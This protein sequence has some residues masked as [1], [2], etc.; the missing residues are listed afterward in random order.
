MAVHFFRVRRF[1]QVVRAGT[2]LLPAWRSRLGWCALIGCALMQPAVSAQEQPRKPFVEPSETHAKTRQRAVVETLPAQNGRWDMLPFHMPIN[3]VHVA[4]MRSGKVLIVSGSGNDPDNKNLQ[5]AVWDPAAATIRTF[6]IGWDMFCDG[7]VVLPDGRPLILGGTKQYDPFLGLPRSAAFDPVSEKFADLPSMG[8]GR[9]YPSGVVLGNGS[10]MVYSGQNDTDGTINPVVQLWN[11]TAWAA[12]GGIFPSLP[13]YPRGHLLP[14]GKVFESGSNRDSQLYDPVAHTWSAVAVT[15]FPHERDYGTSVLL[16]LTPANAWKPRVMILGGSSSD[17]TDTTELIDLSAPTPRWSD[18][19][20]MG[21]PRIHL[22]A[23]LLPN[24]KLLVS[25]GSVVDEDGSTAVKEAQLYDPDANSFSSAS[26]ME[27]PRLYHSNTLLL[28]DARVVALGGNP[29]RKVYQPEIEI[30]SPPYLFNTDGSPARRPAITR[31]T[32]A[33]VLY[34]S[35]FSVRSPDATAIKSVVLL[36]A[37]AATHAFDMEQRLVGLSFTAGPGALTVTAPKNG[38]L[39]PPGY[40]L[41]FILNA[42][43]VP[44]AAQFVRLAAPLVRGKR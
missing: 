17:T 7:M 12:G 28:P 21:K 9:W 15:N 10:V 39:A 36:R 2:A 16:P 11:G 4:L 8:A 18:G 32:P 22:N 38:N 27:V 6:Q 14:T 1:G 19:P 44:S 31:V 34:G 3:P 20:K 26:S 23:T 40:Y 42:Q 24:G 25:G 13:L 30:Y 29:Q 5:A 43:G 37:G 33:S 41:L 35:R